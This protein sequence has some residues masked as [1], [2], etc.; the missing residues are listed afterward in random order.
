M[1]DIEQKCQV[2]LQALSDWAV[3]YAPDM[4]D[5]DTVAEAKERILEHGTLAYI[6][7][8][9][10]Q[11]HA[12]IL[13][14]SEA[15][16]REREVRAK[17]QAMHR[18]AQIAEGAFRGVMNVIDL[19]EPTLRFHKLSTHDIVMRSIKRDFERAVKKA[20]ALQSEER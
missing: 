4:C 10:D 9:T 13:A 1:T 18:R 11:L 12:A 8:A 16:Q 20:S 5:P 3:T 14:V 6:A 19:W 2:A 7:N 17:L 15:D